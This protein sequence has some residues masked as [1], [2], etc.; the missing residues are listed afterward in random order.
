MKT[1]YVA[2]SLTHVKTD[3]EKKELRDFLAWLVTEFNIKLLKWAFDTDTWSPEPVE[4]IYEYDTNM[5]K[6]AD[7]VIALY[8]SDAGSDGRGGE[9]VNRIEVAKKPIRSF[10]KEGVRVSRYPADCFKKHHVPIQTF[11]DFKEMAPA[12]REALELL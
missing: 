3:A 2:T 9:V 4:N 10:A 11:K 8:L 7:L 12:I 5:V 6:E 1:V